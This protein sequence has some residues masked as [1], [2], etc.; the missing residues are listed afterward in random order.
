[1]GWGPSACR[2]RPGTCVEIARNVD[3]L[4]A[5]DHHLPAQPYLLGHHGC[6]ATQEMASAVQHQDLPQRRVRQPPGR[7]VGSGTFA[8][9]LY[10]TL[11]DGLW[12]FPY[13]SNLSER[14]DQA[15]FVLKFCLLNL[16]PQNMNFSYQF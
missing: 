2:G 13:S 9:V 12:T 14:L 10:R 11:E 16:I 7:E 4:T 1:M 3:A 15:I 5:H 6:Q 8:D